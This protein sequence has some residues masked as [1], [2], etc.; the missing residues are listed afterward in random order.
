MPKKERTKIM[1][2]QRLKNKINFQETKKKNKD[3]KKVE[4]KIYKVK[5]E[6]RVKTN[7]EGKRHKQTIKQT[8]RQTN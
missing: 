8:G 7:K 3:S 1:M 4:M 2:T 6:K 5:T